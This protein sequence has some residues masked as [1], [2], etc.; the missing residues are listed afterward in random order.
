ME[1]AAH[2]GKELEMDLEGI[3]DGGGGG[4]WKPQVSSSSSQI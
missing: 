3:N 2:L 1:V 4:H